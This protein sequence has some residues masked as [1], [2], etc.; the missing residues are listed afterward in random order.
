MGL[1]H[2]TAARPSATLRRRFGRTV[3]GSDG[4]IKGR[5]RVSTHIKKQLICGFDHT[6]IGNRTT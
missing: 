5:S 2:T 3:T 1:I 6:D 4:Q